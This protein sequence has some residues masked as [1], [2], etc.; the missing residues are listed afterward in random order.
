M[1]T[2]HRHSSPEETRERILSA[3]RSVYVR[4]GRHGTTTREIAQL[5]GVNEVTLFR[6]FG[7]KDRLLAEMVN[8]CCPQ[9]GI[10]E[11]C[12]ETGDI[13]VD[14]NRVGLTL[15]RGIESVED[16]IRVHMADKD[17]DADSPIFEGPKR[18]HR[19]IIGF[20]QRQVDAE[21]IS[22]DPKRL[23]RAFF[24]M[25]FAHVMGKR[26]WGGQTPTTEADVAYY[27]DIFL[28]GT[29]RHE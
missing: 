10:A 1:E 12:A 27:T 3:A 21:R 20:M 24:G 26:L 23:A 6:H 28:K 14:L 9:G 19:D 5:A 4:N 13:R 17:L 16:L 15:A 7:S 2:A 8:R 18:T 25:I 29:L 22:G 11:G